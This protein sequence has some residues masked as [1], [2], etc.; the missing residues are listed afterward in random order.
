M[1][2]IQIPTLQWRA[3]HLTLKSAMASCLNHARC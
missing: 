3:V 1:V 2:L